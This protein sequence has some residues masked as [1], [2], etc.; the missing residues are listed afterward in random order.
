MVALIF[1]SIDADQLLG[2]IDQALFLFD[3]GDDGA[4]V[5]DVEEAVYGVG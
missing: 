3:P 5:V 2:G 4:L 1:C